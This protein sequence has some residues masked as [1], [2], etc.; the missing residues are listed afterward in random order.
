MAHTEIVQSIKVL[1][2]EIVLEDHLLHQALS[3]KMNHTLNMSVIIA[4]KIK[5]SLLKIRR[6]VKYNLNNFKAN[7]I[8]G[9]FN[10]WLEQNIVEQEMSCYL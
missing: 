2:K 4:T 8:N 1:A 7:Y 5:W 9:H 3:L 6:F 10:R